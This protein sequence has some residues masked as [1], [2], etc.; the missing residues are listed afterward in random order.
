M[1]LRSCEFPSGKV[2]VVTG[3]MLVALISFAAVAVDLGVIA[4]A[5]AQLETVADASALAGA[6]Q[7]VSDYRLGV[8]YTP[9][10][11][12]ANASSKAIAIGQSNTVLNHTAVILSSDVAVGYKQTTP[13]DPTDSTFVQVVN[14]NTNSVQVTAKLDASH[15]GVVPGFFSRIW[16]WNGAVVSVTSTATV[17]IYSIGGFTPGT[18]NS[19]LL[20]MVLSQ[21]AY[22]SIFT[23][24]IDNYSY[25][26]N[27][28]AYGTVTSGSDGVYETSIYPDYSGPGNWGTIKVGVSNNSTST[29]GAQIANG[30][31]PAQM[32]A[33]GFPNP[34]STFSG[35]PGISAGIKGDLSAII[36]KPVVV[37]L[38]SSSSG[39]GNNLTYTIVAYEAVRI[40][41]VSLTGNPKYVVVQ[42]AYS[43]DSTA[44]PG[45]SST[46]QQGGLVRLHLSR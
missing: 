36:G 35:N 26:P 23:N 34:P 9:T 15:V 11:E 27:G 33:A 44:N 40:V 16:G 41:A 31:T 6:R 7:L 32:A 20:P 3:L 39:N 8:N 10:T 37:P 38:Y 25:S 43:T 5:R 45:T 14:A 1:R 12:A 2:L 18:T 17:E 22:N 30:I 21:T 28:G 4:A 29:L 19:S 24:R 46:W 42:P 13:P